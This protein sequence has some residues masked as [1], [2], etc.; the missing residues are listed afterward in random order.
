MC[1]KLSDCQF[2]FPEQ[3]G[4]SGQ[5]HFTYKGDV[6]HQATDSEVNNDTGEGINTPSMTW[7][8]E[9]KK[10]LKVINTQT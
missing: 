2:K 5:I 6:T 7:V 10:Y 1:T 8:A 9:I 4:A 3:A